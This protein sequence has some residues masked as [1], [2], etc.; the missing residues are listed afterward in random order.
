M[1]F[2][3][4]VGAPQCPQPPQ[5]TGEQTV[6]ADSLE[7]LRQILEVQKEHLQLTRA[8]AV[9]NDGCQRWRTFLDRWGN[10]FPNL[11]AGC[12][13]VL[14]HLERAYMELMQ[15]LTSR[16]QDDGPDALD[17]EFSMAEFLDR[18]GMK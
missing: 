2:S 4:D 5:T 11:A 7:I 18:Y 6:P 17:N 16:L 9:A 14:P 1:H 12:K 3:F 8:I 13:E 15:D 10:Q